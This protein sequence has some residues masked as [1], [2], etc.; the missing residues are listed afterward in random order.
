MNLNELINVIKLMRLGYNQD[1]Y[2]LVF[3]HFVNSLVSHGNPN[4]NNFCAGSPRKHSWYVLN[5]THFKTFFSQIF[6]INSIKVFKRNN[7]KY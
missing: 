4:K 5:Q 2:I 6:K 1:L 3:K 7:K